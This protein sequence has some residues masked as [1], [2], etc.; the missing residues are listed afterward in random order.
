MMIDY[1]TNGLKGAYTAYTEQIHGI[2]DNLLKCVYTVH[3][4]LAARQP[5]TPVVYARILAYIQGR[6]TVDTYVRRYIRVHVY[7]TH[8][9]QSAKQKAGFAVI[10]QCNLLG[11]NRP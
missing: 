2:Q 8:P 10:I 5:Y 3:F 11:H 6:F 9:Y 7:Y 1:F 4:P